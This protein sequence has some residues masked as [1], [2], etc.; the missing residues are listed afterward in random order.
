MFTEVLAANVLKEYEL[1]VEGGDTADTFH[2]VP[3]HRGM[4]HAVKVAVVSATVMESRQQS[5]TSVWQ[6]GYRWLQLLQSMQDQT[7]LFSFGD[8][9]ASPP[10]SAFTI[11]DAAQVWEMLSRS[12]TDGAQK[13]SD[14]LYAILER[15]LPPLLAGGVHTPNHRWELASA[16]ARCAAILS[17]PKATARAR[18]WLSEGIDALPCGLYSERSANYSVRVSNPSLLVLAHLLGED[19]LAETVHQNLHAI[20]KTAYADPT[21]QPTCGQIKPGLAE[22]IFSR[23]QDQFDEGFPLGP[24]FW[25][26]ARFADSCPQCSSGAIWAF[27]SGKVDS[28]DTL[29]GLWTDPLVAAGLSS[30]RGPLDDSTAQPQAAVSEKTYFADIPV[31]H[32]RNE[33]GFTTVYAGSDVPRMGRVA[34][35]LACN[36][37][38]LK[39]AREDTLIRSVRLS[40]D[41]FDIGPFRPEKLE[42]QNQPEMSSLFLAESVSGKYYQPLSQE[43]LDHVGQYRLEHEGRFAAAMSFANRRRTKVKLDTNVSIKIVGESLTILVEPG[44]TA[45]SQTLEIAFADDVKIE[46]AAPLGNDCYWMSDR[47]EIVGQQGLVFS[48]LVDGPAQKPQ[49]RYNPG[50]DYAFLHGTDALGGQRLYIS[51]QSPSSLAVEFAR[52]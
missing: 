13:I 23:R 15:A 29:V 49:L 2:E 26:F 21:A 42:V 40:R 17:A 24:F 3:G 11:N 34:S 7:G 37:T 38:F 39:F 20:L 4:M 32:Q 41:F 43:A 31:W 6:Q 9:I 46:G 1:L 45:C 10:D 5:A 30:L 25:L 12:S 51:W 47:V 19:H 36:P 50:E 18:Q 33:T 22:T 16:L 35:G 44:S 48:V 27:G 8:N 52:R 28:V 14:G